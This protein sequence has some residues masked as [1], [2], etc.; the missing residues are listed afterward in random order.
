[1]SKNIKNVKKMTNVKIIL[2][3]QYLNEYWSF[4][5]DDNKNHYKSD[6]FA[7]TDKTAV[8]DF[9]LFYDLKKL[10]Q[11]LPYSLDSE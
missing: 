4:E 5:S 1:M 10:K 8:S 9:G 11:H 2:K 6:W 3:R 7:K